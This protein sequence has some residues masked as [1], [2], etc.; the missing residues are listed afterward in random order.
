MA[1]KTAKRSPTLG[2]VVRSALSVLL[3]MPWCTDWKAKVLKYIAACGTGVLGWRYTTCRDCRTEQVAGLGCQSSYCPSCGAQKRAEWTEQ[4]EAELVD[5]PYFHFVFTMPSAL[6]PFFLARQRPLYNA[7]FDAVKDTL[8]KFA[9][10]KRFLGG[11]PPGFSVLHTTNRALGYH[12][13]IHVVVAGAGVDPD[14]GKVVKAKRPTYLFPA[15]AL[16]A[17]FK[18]KLIAN[19][20]QLLNRGALL[21][22]PTQAAK[23]RGTLANVYPL[24]WQV[25]TSHVDAGPKAAIRYLAQY[26][27]RTAISNKR[28]LRLQGGKVT[29]AW[30]DRKTKASRTRTLPVVDFVE[31]FQKHILPTRFRRVRLWG[32]LA[33]SKKATL[34]PLLQRALPLPRSAD[35][36]TK[37]AEGRYC[38]YCKSTNTSSLIGTLRMPDKIPNILPIPPPD[39][40]LGIQQVGPRR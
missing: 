24:N 11:L 17:V 16:A 36:S 40:L 26:T 19:I 10:N 20:R 2:D 34:L 29:Y 14:S 12:P 15:R 27:Y 37:K 21:L 25:H 9:L 3:T 1:R 31:M 22:N 18:G 23:L 35:Q 13:H 4:R 32:A 6:Y 8:L 30:T 7:M 38:P 39:L 28:I 5:A 33:N